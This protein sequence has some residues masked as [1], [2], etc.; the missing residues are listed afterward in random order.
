MM[1]TDWLDGSGAW[2]SPWPDAALVTSRLMTPGLHDSGA[3]VGIDGEHP[4]H[5]VERDDHAAGYGER[6]AGQRLPAAAG[7][8]GHAEAVADAHHRGD[9]LGRLGGR[10]RRGADERR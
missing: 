7:D 9:L 2:A 6:A 3:G 1:Q 5:P 10:P 8:E 4:V